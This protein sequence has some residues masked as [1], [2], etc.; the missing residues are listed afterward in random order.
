MIFYFTGTGNSL[1]VA[2]K[3]QE[4][5]GGELIDI[6]QALNENNFSYRIKK[7]EKIGIVFPVYFWGLA[8]IVDEF[9][10]QLKLETIDKNPFIYTI[11]TCGGNIR[12]AGKDLEK[13]LKSK[14]LELSSCYSLKMPSNYVI[15][16]DLAK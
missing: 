1:Y 9:V 5:D 2:Q 4:T 6:S 11:V 12:N 10:K 8:T 7:G 13:L 16:H 14:N 15:M 3:I